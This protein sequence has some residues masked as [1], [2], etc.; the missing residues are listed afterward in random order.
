M[1]MDI[2]V[3]N[4]PDIYSLVSE[5]LTCVDLRNLGLV[6]NKRIDYNVRNYSKKFFMPK[7]IKVNKGWLSLLSKL[8]DLRSVYLSITGFEDDITGMLEVLP[9]RVRN[10]SFNNGVK[11]KSSDI[12]LLPARL[13]ILHLS[14]KYYTD[15][16]PPI[17][18]LA[19][20]TELYSPGTNISDPSNFPPN[21]KVIIIGE[22]N[23]TDETVHLLPKKLEKLNIL[24]VKLSSAGIPL[25]PQTL[26]SLSVEKGMQS[27]RNLPPNLE[28]LS[29]GHSSIED[30]APLPKNLKK[31][32]LRKPLRI[33]LES[34][35]YL[36]PKLEILNLPIQLSFEVLN[37][38]PKTL[39]ALHSDVD[40]RLSNDMLSLLPPNLK[41]LSLPRN[42]ILDVPNCKHIG[43]SHIVILN[44]TYLE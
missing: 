32:E 3:L 25:L 33:S 19:Y 13:E 4:I 27:C 21:L 14:T 11:L 40:I 17:N 22:C 15:M 26:K 2:N 1:T 44:Y 41:S 37:L 23:L 28:E 39:R 38:L 16:L 9:S 8:R 43:L 31:L 20:L 12:S 18:N 34:L 7:S 6:C 5:Y 30:F 10:L 42:H 29:L 35:Q 36:P 24:H